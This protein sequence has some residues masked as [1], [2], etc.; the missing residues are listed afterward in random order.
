MKKVFSMIGA[1]LILGTFVLTPNTANADIWTFT[2]K[3]IEV[4]EGGSEPIHSKCVW[5]IQLSNCIVGDIKLPTV[6]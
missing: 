5:S 6:E 4:Y 1:L 2:G 3:W